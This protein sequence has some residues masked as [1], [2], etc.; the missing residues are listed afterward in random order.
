MVAIQRDIGQFGCI[1]KRL[2][3]HLGKDTVEK[4]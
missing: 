1:V 4:D 2:I 3:A